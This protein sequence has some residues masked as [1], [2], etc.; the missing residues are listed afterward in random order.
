MQA[1]FFNVI[2]GFMV[3]KKIFKKNRIWMEWLEQPVR[4][5]LAG[6]WKWHG[7]ARTDRVKTMQVWYN[8]ILNTHNLKPN[9]FQHFGPNDSF[10]ATC[11]S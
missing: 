6:A 11:L 8:T 1:I 3:S 2:S 5:G 4:V 7:P 9:I 10:Q